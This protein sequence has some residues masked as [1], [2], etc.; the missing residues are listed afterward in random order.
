VKEE[1]MDIG[2]NF[3]A[4]HETT[5]IGVAAMLCGVALLHLVMARTIK[6]RI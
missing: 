1:D 6:R 3:I 4:A 2:S 5:L